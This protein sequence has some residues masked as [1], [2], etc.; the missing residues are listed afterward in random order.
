LA[1]SDDEHR[2][3]FKEVTLNR[4]RPA[5]RR[6]PFPGPGLWMGWKQPGPNFQILGVGQFRF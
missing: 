4:G 2:G 5:P 3:L 6:K 1:V